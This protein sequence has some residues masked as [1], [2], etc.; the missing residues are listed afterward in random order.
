MAQADAV[1]RR[2]AADQPAPGR[3]ARRRRSRSTSSRSCRHAAGLQLQGR[4]QSRRSST[5]SC[6]S[7]PTHNDATGTGPLAG[8]G[9]DF[10]ARLTMRDVILDPQGQQGEA[11]QDE[12][13]HYKTRYEPNVGGIKIPVD[14][15]WT[16]GRGELGK[17]KFRFVNHP[18]RG[19][20]RPEDPRGAGQG[21]DQGPA[22]DEGAGDP[23]RRPQLRR[24]PPPRAREARRRAG[25]RGARRSSASRTTARQSCCFD[26]LFDPT[27]DFD[28][29][30]D[31]VLSKPALETVKASVTGRRRRAHAVRSLAV[32]PRRRGQ[33]LRFPATR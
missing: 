2:R 32:R 5:P 25:V 24:R 26:S 30:V 4:G 22:Q 21:A 3:D 16:L 27:P 17:S 9:A 8:L 10:D 12:A 19:L 11:R 29:T 31:H 23:R 33:P 7:T 20:R 6:R 15:G 1:G 13:G 28:H 14:R 18:P